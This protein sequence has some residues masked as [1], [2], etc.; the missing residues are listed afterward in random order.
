MRRKAMDD[1]Y[2]SVA[3]C[4]YNGAKF[5]QEQL[6]SIASQTCPPYEL[7]VC[8]DNST[9]DTVEILEA[10]RN[11]VPF[12]IR[13]FRN[14][15]RLGS[16]RN[17]EKAI[18]LCR[19]DLVTLADQDDVWKQD[20][21]EKL[22]QVFSR[23]PLA[24]GVFSDAELVGSE[25]QGIGKTLWHSLGVTNR[26]RRQLAKG[27]VEGYKALLRKN[28]ITGATFAFKK[29]CYDSVG[30]IPETWVH[31]AWIAINIVLKGSIASISEPL[32]GYRQHEDNQIGVYTPPVSQRIRDL[33]SLKDG[34]R[35]MELLKSSLLEQGISSDYLCLL[36]EKIKHLKARAS[37]SLGW[38]EIV[39]EC[40]LGNYMKYSGGHRSLAKDCF[41]V[42]RKAG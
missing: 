25:G 9:D 26:D 12:R 34:L 5:L 7:V 35:N 17:F 40:W 42:F 21:L 32:I 8:D 29:D 16:T 2:L 22:L 15:K 23:H 14:H 39:R 27:G 38:K 1:R 10:F 31:D 37:E 18:N 30:E 11:K 3:M 13:V 36:D 24:V 4:T 6:E 41:R 33:Q 19:G 28:V 20:K